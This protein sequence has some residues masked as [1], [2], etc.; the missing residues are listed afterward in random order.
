MA[1]TSRGP[2]EGDDIIVG[3]K[4]ADL[5]H[6]YGGD[7]QISGGGGNDRLFGDDGNDLVNGDDGDDDVRGGNGNDTLNGG[8]GNDSVNGGAG[9]D[10]MSGG[11]GADHFD[12]TA[13]SDS[14][15]AAVD[16]ITDYSLA[17]GD[18]LVFA[19]LD[20]NAGADGL[21]AW[22][23]VETLGAPSGENGQATLTCDL[24]TEMTTLNLYNND[25]DTNADFT[26]AFSGQYG[27]GDIRLTVLD[28]LGGPPNYDGIIW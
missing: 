4:V 6:G 1:K 5:L 24:A 19:A 20:A 25:G 22:N 10:V 8:T 21:Q 14:A 26:L 3:K 2:G 11:A 9:T 27:A 15:G 7:D 28:M 17:S 12:F 16:R 23:Y 18:D 13:F